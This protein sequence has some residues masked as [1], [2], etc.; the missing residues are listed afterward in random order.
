MVTTSCL[1]AA[2]FCLY[3]HSKLNSTSNAWQ[4]PVIKGVP[5]LP[6]SLSERAP[7]LKDVGQV[8]QAS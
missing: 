5:E 6:T 8:K 4:G 3:S 2:G 7:L 1:C